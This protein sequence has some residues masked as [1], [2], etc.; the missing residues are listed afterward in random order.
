MD[1]K[2]NSNSNANKNAIDSEKSAFER[3][4]SELKNTI[5]GVL[6]VLLKDEEVS[7]WITFIF[8]FIEFFQIITFAFHENVKSPC[9]LNESYNSLVSDQEHLELRF[10]YGWNSDFSSILPFEILFHVH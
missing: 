9:P 7:I 4:E 10:S 3:F 8:T 2:T 1:L 6:F 5:F